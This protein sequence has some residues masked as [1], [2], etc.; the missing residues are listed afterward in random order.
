MYGGN[1]NDILD[2]GTGDDILDGGTVKDDTDIFIFKK[3]YGKDTIL[4]INATDIIKI[5]NNIALENI[6]IRVENNDLI[7]ALA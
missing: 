1:G 3:G 5:D 7:L 2:G 4:N 6:E